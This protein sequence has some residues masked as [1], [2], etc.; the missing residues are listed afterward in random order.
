MD[1]LARGND[2]LIVNPAVG[3]DNT[4]S[5]GGSDWLWAVTAVYLMAFI[6][7]LCFCFASPESQRVFHYTFTIALLVGSVTYFA[8]ASNLGWSAQASGQMFWAK[9]VNWSITFPS[10]VLS[11]G[12]LSGVSWTTIV[13]NI[14]IAFIWTFTYLAAAYTPTSYKWGFFTFGTFSYVVLAM[15]TLNESREEAARRGIGRDYILLAAWANLLWL[16]YPVGFGLTDGGH[17]LGVTSGAIFF[18]VLDILMV[19]VLGFGYVLLGRHWD[20]DRL[21]LA[22]SEYR[23]FGHGRQVEAKTVPAEMTRADDASPDTA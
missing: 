12:L 21:E 7:L 19:P 3:V 10:V 18:G 8:Q 15:S 20:W 2:A 22:F 4:L 23:G 1:L 14:F 9:Y 13:C 16:L 6:G 5:L 11:L 17:V